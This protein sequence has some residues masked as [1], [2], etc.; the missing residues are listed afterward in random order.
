MQFNFQNWT[1]LSLSLIRRY[2]TYL[3]TLSGGSPGGICKMKY[4]KLSEN[5]KCNTAN[6]L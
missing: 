2:N 4:R 1:A 6:Y 5:W 3:D